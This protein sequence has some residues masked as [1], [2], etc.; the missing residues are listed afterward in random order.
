MK[1]AWGSERDIGLAEACNK[2][3]DRIGLHASVRRLPEALTLALPRNWEGR[4]KNTHN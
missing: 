1:W 2:G 3:M 4:G